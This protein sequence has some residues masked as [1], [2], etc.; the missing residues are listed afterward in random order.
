[1]FRLLIDTCVWLDLAKDY[2]QMALLDALDELVRQSKATVILPRTVVNEFARNKRR[3]IEES[4]RSISGTLKRARDIVGTLGEGTGKRFALA[5]LDEI[6]HRLPG[7]GDVA[8]ETIG[9]IE[10]LFDDSTTIET[11]DAVL[12]RAAQRAIDRRAPFHR[13]RNNMDDAVLIETYGDL[14]NRKTPVRTRFGFVTHN[15]NDF[16]QPHSDNRRPHPDIASYFSKIKS[17]YFITLGEA[18]QRIEPELM[19]DITLEREWT[20]DT[21]LLSEILN[22]IDELTD[23]VWYDRHQMRL[24]LIEN[25]ALKIVDKE[26]FPID[27]HTRRPIQRDIWKGALKAARRVEK[28]Y[29]VKNLGAWSDFEW[30]MINGKLSALR[31]VLGDEW[32]NLDT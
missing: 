28:K 9:R 18:L 19:S 7:L 8:I 1:M 12:L 20:Q 3:I 29:G 27:A 26:I 5:Q 24:Q 31:W 6:D 10:R 11:S 23:K 15:T 22:S 21:R 25:G 30:G 14:V 32:D 16:S 13:Q 4:G 2:H 17:L